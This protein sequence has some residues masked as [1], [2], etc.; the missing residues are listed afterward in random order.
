LKLRA[1]TVADAAAITA[2]YGPYV[3][4]SAVSFETE[5]PDASAMAARIAAGGD[6]YPWVVAE[7]AS[8]ALAGYAY[9][10]AFR[11]RPAYRYAVET[12]VYLAREA[13]G[14]GTGWWLYSSLLA[15]L[16][17]Q[18]FAQAVAAITLPNPRSVA[19]HEGAGFR[20]AGT[21]SQ[22]GFKLGAWH[23]VGL[24]QRPLAPARTPPVEPR[25]LS[26]QPLII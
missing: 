16:E 22:L 24:W 19:L 3:T 9:A 5:A 1:A 6:L 14:R 21:Y 26:D 12:S 18:G 8:G 17:A 25:R 2:I 13:Q 4:S 15:T 10:S 23:D 11:P 20:P 7:H